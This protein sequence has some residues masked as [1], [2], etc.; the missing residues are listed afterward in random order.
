MVDF[1]CLQMEILLRSSYWP[2]TF[3]LLYIVWFL[4]KFILYGRIVQLRNNSSNMY[5]FRQWNLWW[6]AESRRKAFIEPLTG[7]CMIILLLGYYMKKLKNVYL[8][9]AHHLS[10]LFLYLTVQEIIFPFYMVILCPWQQVWFVSQA[11]RKSSW[12]TKYPRVPYLKSM[13]T[14]LVKLI[15]VASWTVPHGWQDIVMS[16]QVVG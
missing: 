10:S 13:A 5:M 6:L 16:L 11:L 9:L 8:N 14:D 3:S 7:G 12:P 15:L 1:F 2:P 4:L